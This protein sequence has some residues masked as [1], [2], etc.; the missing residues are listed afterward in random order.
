MSLLRPAVVNHPPQAA[1][2]WTI[3]ALFV[4]ALPH[5]SAMP[6]VLVVVILMILVWRALAGHFQW[7]AL[8]GL[9]RIALTFFLIGLIIV[10]YGGLWGRRTAASLLCI[11]LAA[12]ML[13]TYRARDLRLVASVC[14]FLIATQFLFNERLAYLLYLIAGCWLATLALWQ[15]QRIDGAVSSDG[16]ELRNGLV[17]AARL[18]ALAL[19]VAL[20][21]FLL[22]PRL[23]QPLWGLPDQ[24]MDGRTGLSENMS[25][26]TIAELFIDDSPAFRVEFEGATPTPDQ[27][28]WRGPVLWNFDGTTWRPAFFSINSTRD[29]VPVTASSIRYRI[30][31]EPHERRWLLGLDHPVSSS[32]P[33]SRVTVDYVLVSRNP[34]TTLSQYEVISTP[35]FTDSPE[36]SVA[37][38]MLA[39]QLPADRNPRTLALAAELRERHAD[40]RE[41]IQAVLN[42]FREEAFYYSLST[43]PL[44]RHSADEFLFDLR[45]GYC[46]YYASAFAVLMRAAG[47]PTRIVTGYQGGFMNAAGRYMLVRQSDAHAWTEVWLA[48][49]GWTRIDPTAA[50]SPRRILE[51]SRSVVSSG[52][53]ADWNWLR[54]LRNRYD[55]VQ[56]L[57]NQWILGFDAER[58][59]QMLRQ[60]GLPDL[61]PTTIGL[62]MMAVLLAVGIP[63]ALMLLREAGK[64]ARSPAHQAWLNLLRRLKRRGLAK[65]PHE[66]PLE[67]AQR[68]APAL[69]DDERGRE[70]VQL[71][72]M[73]S[74]LHYGLGDDSLAAAFI[75]RADLFRPG[76]RSS[77]P[78]TTGGTG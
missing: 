19:P 23:A 70:L 9:L 42:W 14:F 49:S 18:L 26:G 6:A 73:F 60:L 46:E 28:Y 77:T 69:E 22:F 40:D 35:D 29:P 4:A 61:G 53:V 58:Q 1:L 30:Q 27:L 13:E 24:V 68:Q 74:R 8:P 65:H 63:L 56:H 43:A 31:L 15:V 72:L 51:G 54:Q 41:L 44:G 21:L 50:V 37:Q 52:G 59:R 64:R 55:R 48:G 62:L 2:L 32:M 25:P 71:A 67:F 45:T 20:V 38:R 10:S 57:W 12:K 78:A 7:R 16:P 36:L 39:L 66:T 47:I 17:Q 76:R 75:Q 3:A 34:I 33:E 11:M 5:L